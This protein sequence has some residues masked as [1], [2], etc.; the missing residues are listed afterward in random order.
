MFVS[1]LDD[2]AWYLYD[3]NRF[4]N[5][6]VKVTFTLNDRDDA[7]YFSKPLGQKTITIT[8]KGINSGGSQ[9]G[10][11]TTKNISTQ[12]Q[13]WMRPESLMTLSKKE[14]IALIEGCH[15]VK[16]KKSLLIWSYNSKQYTVFFVYN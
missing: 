11:T 12:S 7:D 1:F 3:S 4:L 16:I 13:L 14:G 8:N 9:S 6:K 15:P 10:S 5:A 2:D